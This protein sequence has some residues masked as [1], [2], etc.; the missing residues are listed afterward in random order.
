MEK[1]KISLKDIG[2]PRIIIMFVAGILLIL[3]T[4]PDLMGGNKGSKEKKIDLEHSDW[5]KDMNTTSHDTN[6]Y[7]SELEGRLENI[8]RKVKG[9]GEVEVMIT[10]KTSGEKIPLKDVPY[11]Q[12]GLNEEDGEGG[13]RANNRIQK[14]ESTVLVTNEDG[15]NQ[16]YIL[17]ER[18]PE[19]EGV[20]VIA[21]GGDN[22][23]VIKDIVEAAEVLFNIPTHKVKVMKMSDGIN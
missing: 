6:T 22:V 21:E 3:L 23:L 14:E 12:E 1:K 19:V 2:M 11:T 20:V 10:L 16:P 13:S 9:I 5:Q 4:F 7:I 8:L 15:D 17:Q 18:Q